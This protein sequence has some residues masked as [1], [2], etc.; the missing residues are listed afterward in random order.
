M[1][2]ELKKVRVLA[3]FKQLNLLERR[4]SERPSDRWKDNV[5]INPKVV[6]VTV[7]NWVTSAQFTEY[8]KSLVNVEL[9]LQVL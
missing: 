3:K 1:L 2:A 4:S 6:G 7:R 8:W 5:R 9:K